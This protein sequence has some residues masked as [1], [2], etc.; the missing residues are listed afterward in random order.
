MASTSQCASRAGREPSTGGPVWPQRIAFGCHAGHASAADALMQQ[1][2]WA[3]EAR[4]SEVVQLAVGRHITSVIEA[5][6]LGV[7]VAKRQAGDNACNYDV[8]ASIREGISSGLSVQQ[9]ARHLEEAKAP[10]RLPADVLPVLGPTIAEL[11]T[12]EELDAACAQLLQQLVLAVRKANL[13]LLRARLGLPIG[14]GGTLSPE[15]V[16]LMTSAAVPLPGCGGI[17]G[18]LVDLAVWH[19]HEHIALALLKLADE[20]GLAGVLASNSRHAVF[21]AVQQDAQELLRALLSHGAD[22]A[23]VDPV[24]GSAIRCAAEQSRAAAAVI[25]IQ[26]GAWDPEADKQRVLGLLQDRGLLQVAD[27]GSGRG[28]GLAAMEANAL[29]EALKHAQGIETATAEM[30]TMTSTNANAFPT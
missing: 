29:A 19:G 17:C 26:H 16:S 3:H 1:G 30:A 15:A 6:G 21:W 28:I 4:R 11:R 7:S 23:Q 27:C 5:A 2:A 9:V 13:P 12:T 8:D 14:G 18:N 20:N 22:A 10:K 24:C 25:L